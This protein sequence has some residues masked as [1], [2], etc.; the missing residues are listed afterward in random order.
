ML[1]ACPCGICRALMSSFI[2]IEAKPRKAAGKT[3]ARRV[4]RE[5]QIP[6]VAY[7]KTLA[8]TPLAVSPKEV[9]AVLRSE[10][11]RNSI[12]QMTGIPGQDGLT[13]MI[14]E[15]THHP[16]SRELVHVDFVA[17]R[18]DQ[19]VDVD[20]PL[21]PIGKPPGIAEGGVLRQVYR[22][23]PVRCIA[24]NVPA[25]I[26]VDIG[27]LHMGDH[28]ETKELKLPEGVK[29]LVPPEQTLIAV[30]A[31]EAEVVE[32]VVVAEVA[33]VAGAPGAAAV[34]G[35]A[36]GTPG[37]AAGATPAAGAEKAPAKKEDKKK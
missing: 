6:A 11:G 24:T 21:V 15:Y 31:P 35:A 22:F 19:E 25:K 29:P 14:R 33:A 26:E 13:V 18:P 7:G 1:G 34:P 5:G 27:H 12:I 2:T 20:V 10:R 16:V 30:V 3:E 4:R 36:P 23:L 28:V 17:I 37:A 9:L 8:S 32:E